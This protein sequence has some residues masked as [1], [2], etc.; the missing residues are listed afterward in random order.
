MLGVG[1]PADVLKSVTVEPAG[2]TSAVPP[3]LFEDEMQQLQQLLL[4]NH[5]PLPHGACAKVLPNW[6]GKRQG[7][8]TWTA[9]FLQLWYQKGYAHIAPLLRSFAAENAC[10]LN[11]CVMT[12]T[13]PN[14]AYTPFIT[15]SPSMKDISNSFPQQCH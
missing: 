10:P 6:S 14:T 12:V 5:Q 15:G 1:K 11:G 9:C 7:P 3:Q 2:A 13:F 4:I 8:I